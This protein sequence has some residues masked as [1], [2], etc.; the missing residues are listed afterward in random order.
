MN[1]ICPICHTFFEVRGHNHKYCSIRCR[2]IHHKKVY[3]DKHKKIPEP[4]PG[5][6]IL[7]H[8]YCKKC[9]ELVLII[10]E[11]EV[12]SELPA[13]VR[14]VAVSKFHPNEALEEAYAGW[15]Y[16]CT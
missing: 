15:N 5:K 4:E 9:S 6:K 3:Y 7:R 13:G 2:K 11:K 14:L 10:N 1:K 16:R 8:F 12:L